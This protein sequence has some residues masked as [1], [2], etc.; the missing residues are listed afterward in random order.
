MREC[1][2]LI[3]SVQQEGDLRVVTH[4]NEAHMRSMQEDEESRQLNHYRTKN[5]VW[6]SLV[7]DDWNLRLIPFTK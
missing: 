3:K 7:T 6:P 5:T 4:Q 1:E 2:D